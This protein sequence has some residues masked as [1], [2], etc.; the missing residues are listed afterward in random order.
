[1]SGL[2]SHAADPSMRYCCL[3]TCMIVNGGAMTTQF[4]LNTCH[5]SKVCP[6]LFLA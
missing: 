3:Y 1:M 4:V 5:M 6:R 2:K